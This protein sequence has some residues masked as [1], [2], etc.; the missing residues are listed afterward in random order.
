MLIVLYLT[1]K[2]QVAEL[3]KNTIMY[4]VILFGQAKE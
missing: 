4:E 1:K 2:N 3:V